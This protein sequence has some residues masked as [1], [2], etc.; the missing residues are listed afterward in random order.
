VDF[1]IRHTLL[2]GKPFN[3]GPQKKRKGGVWKK[4]G[5]PREAGTGGI[6]APKKIEKKSVKGEKREI[7]AR[8]NGHGRHTGKLNPC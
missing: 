3:H 6:F 4:S 2:S 7:Q 5:K 1:T 8:G